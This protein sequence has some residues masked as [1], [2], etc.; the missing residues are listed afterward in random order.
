MPST[1]LGLATSGV[2]GISRISLQAFGEIVGRR[3]RTVAIDA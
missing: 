3:N 1:E 2:A